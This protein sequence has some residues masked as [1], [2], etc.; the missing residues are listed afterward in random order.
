VVRRQRGNEAPGGAEDAVTVMLGCVASEKEHRYRKE[1]DQDDRYRDRDPCSDRKVAPALL[2]QRRSGGLWRRD[3]FVRRVGPRG[4]MIYAH[5]LA[6]GRH[7][8]PS[9]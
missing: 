8:Y 9:V 3:I 6:V 5:V 1:P 2:E 4:A 7:Q